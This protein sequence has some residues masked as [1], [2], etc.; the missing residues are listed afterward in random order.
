MP[1]GTTRASTRRRLLQRQRDPERGAAPLAVPDRDRPLVAVDD[2]LCNRQTQARPPAR[3]AARPPEALEDM[4][5]VGWI[6]APPIVLDVELG[7]RAVEPDGY[8]DLA[9]ARAVPDRVVDEDRHELAQPG[10]IALDHDRGRIDDD[11][12]R[13]G[14]GRLGQRRGRVGRDIAEIDRAPLERDRT[15]VRTR[16]QKQV[17][18]E[19]GQVVDLRADIVKRLADRM[20]RLIA[21]ALEMLEGA[22]NDRQRGAQ[23]VARVGGELALATE[24]Q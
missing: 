9:A 7:R 13:L 15:G 20:D 16:K 24:G 2:P 8:P 1:P 14:P 6:D 19:G 18:D 17:V 12:D 3:R 22:P 5:H 10:G 23:L 11:P 4:R 21:M